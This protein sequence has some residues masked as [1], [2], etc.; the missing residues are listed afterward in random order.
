MNLNRVCKQDV[1]LQCEC[2]EVELKVIE[3]HVIYF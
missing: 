3:I 2:K 1:E